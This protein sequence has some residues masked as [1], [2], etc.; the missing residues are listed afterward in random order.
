MVALLIGC[1]GGSPGLISQPSSGNPALGD[2]IVIKR[3]AQHYGNDI[4]VYSAQFYGNDATVYKRSGFVLTPYLT[5][6]AGFSM[7]GG[8]VT[9]PNGYWYIA[10]GGDADT[11]VYKTT[12]NG[13]VP[14]LSDTLTD[15][16]Q[17]PVNVDATPSRQLVA[18]SNEGTASMAG[19]VSVYLNGATSPSRILAYGSDVLQ[20]EGV[21]VDHQ[22]N[23][24]WSFNDLTKQ[25]G[26]SIVEFA[27]CNGGGTLLIS[28]LTNAGGIVF[29]QSDNLIYVDQA[30]GIWECQKTSAPS[31]ANVVAVDNKVL[32]HPTNINFDHKDKSLWVADEQGYIDA[33]MLPK[34][35]G[36]NKKAKLEMQNSALG[37]PFGVAPAPGG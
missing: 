18:V 13:P 12:K 11:L 35:N 33:Y 8:T 34:G 23:C 1:G 31:C 27:A 28:G 5:F 9:T 4:F 30:T 19:S 22:G 21:A 14:L 16:G 26:G 10:N 25:N 15:Y 37:Q 7:P 6:Y 29:D 17:F 32:F 2:S 3:D 36:K 24:Y 20:G